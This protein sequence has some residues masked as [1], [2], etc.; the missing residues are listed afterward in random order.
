MTTDDDRIAYLAG[1]GPGPLD[2][3]E[4]H[5]LDEL[6][7]ILSEPALWSDPDPDLEDSIVAAVAAE[8]AGTGPRARPDHRSARSRWARPAALFGAAAAVATLVVATAVVRSEGDRSSDLLAARLEPTGLLPDA[9][10]EATLRR[11]DSG[12]RIELDASGLPRL[13]DGRFY[14]A[15]LE[16]DDGNLVAVGSFNEG[17]DVVLWAGVSPRTH[18]RLTI[19]EERADGDAASSGRE[20]LTGRVEAD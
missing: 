16:D 4:R 12:W 2:E 1:E 7:R 5:E 3:E 19:T 17:Q 6:R 13:D 18:Q 20:V 11:S 10:G 9:A 8:A 14:Q 15:W